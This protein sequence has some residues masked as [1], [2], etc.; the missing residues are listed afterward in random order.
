M[1]AKVTINL[2]MGLDHINVGS[3]LLYGAAKM[4]EEDY[5]SEDRDIPLF[6]GVAATKRCVGTMY[7]RVEG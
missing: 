4:L 5:L 1:A 6:V 3:A 2:D 7:I